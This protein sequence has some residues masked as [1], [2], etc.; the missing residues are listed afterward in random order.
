MEIRCLNLPDIFFFLSQF[1]ER[2]DNN[3]TPCT[4]VRQSRTY[5]FI[6]MMNEDQDDNARDQIDQ[7]GDNVGGIVREQLIATVVSS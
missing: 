6:I 7:N 5:R 3:V 1:R 2:D 4:C